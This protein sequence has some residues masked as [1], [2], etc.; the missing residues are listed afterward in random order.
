MINNISHS[1]ATLKSGLVLVTGLLLASTWV[2]RLRLPK[3]PGLRWNLS[4]AR[5]N[6]NNRMTAKANQRLAQR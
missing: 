4:T 5:Q 1:G 6:P 2:W 3:P